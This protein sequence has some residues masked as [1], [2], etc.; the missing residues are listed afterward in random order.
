MREKMF[1]T[2]ISVLMGMGLFAAAPA[3]AQTTQPAQGG[4]PAWGGR[5]MM[6]RRMPGVFGSVTA[7]S[8]DTLTVQSKAFGPNATSSGAT[9]TYSVDATNA[10]VMKRGATSTVAAIGV[11]DTVM[12]QGTVS[13]TSVT[14]TR[15]NDGVPQMGTMGEDNFAA[16]QPIP[17]LQGNGEPVVGG[18]VSAISG[19][20]L[21]VTNASNITYSIDAT[22]ATVIKKNATSSVADIASGDS[23]IVQGTV[24][25]TS[26][27]ASTVIDQGT[28][29]TSNGIAQGGAPMRGVGGFFGA[30]GGLFRRVFGFF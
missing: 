3:F 16:H 25:G 28:A 17:Q 11:G 29:R 18:N 30:I 15:I 20:M 12:V 14:A 4:G 7:I 8:G 23:V 5:G 21:T 6:M 24:N 22:N 10:T 19:D 9:T 26:V 27:T 1:Y 13:G 2:I